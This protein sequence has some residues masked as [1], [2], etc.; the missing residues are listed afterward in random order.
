MIEKYNDITYNE[1]ALS[2]SSS[3]RKIITYKNLLGLLLFVFLVGNMI[4]FIEGQ[5]ILLGI[6]LVGFYIVYFPKLEGVIQLEN[7]LFFYWLVW[8]LT[9]YLA[10]ISEIYVD[11][12]LDNV[13]LVAQILIMNLVIAGITKLR[14]SITLN[15]YGLAIG[16]IALI[17]AST[18]WGDFQ[19]TESKLESTQQLGITSNPNNFAYLL[20]ISTSALL[21]LWKKK[22]SV[23][24]RFF[25]AIV[26][27][28][29]AFS[30]IASGSRKAYIGLIV[31][32]ILWLWN[33]YRKKISKQPIFIIII[34]IIFGIIFFLTDYMLSNTYMGK[35]FKITFVDQR[36]QIREYDR[37]I[38]YQ[39]GIQMIA[40]NPI[41]GVGLGNYQ[42]HSSLD[43]ESHSDYIEVAASTGI[44][45]FII[46]FSIY[47][48][49]WLRL[50]TTQK[51]FKKENILYNIGI[52]KAYMITILI[53]AAGR[54]NFKSTITWYFLASVMGYASS[55]TNQMNTEILQREPR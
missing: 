33:C 43:A 10:N 30:I 53:L 54:P 5:I 15:F 42:I 13:E 47:L 35:R 26:L 49:L 55:L 17:I 46:Y 22:S 24:W 45:G 41:F 27:C 50:S 4:I 44:T 40:E 16:G 19:I 25:I 21:F 36:D 52:I 28:L 48:V 34:F 38:L 8:S 32:I 31:L 6:M 29:F 9:A 39:E 37:I 23:K 1:V 20:L 7:I 11:K 12:F 2:P 14:K 18:I 51:Y 3:Y